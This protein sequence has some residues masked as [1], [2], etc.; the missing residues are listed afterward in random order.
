MDIAFRSTT[1]AYSA[2]PVCVRFHPATKPFAD[3]GIQTTLSCPGTFGC[4]IVR[5]LLVVYTRDSDLFER[6]AYSQYAS[7][8]CR[9]APRLIER[10]LREAFRSSM[11]L[12]RQDRS[13]IEGDA[14]PRIVS[15]KQYGEPDVLEFVDVQA[16]TPQADEVR[17]RVKA[18]GLNRAESMWRRGDYVEPVNL[19]ARLG[20]ESA[21][22]VDAIGSNV[23]HVAVGDAVST[24]PS[25]SMNDYG[26]YGEVVVAPKHAVV[27]IADGVSF[28]QATAIWNPFITPYGAFIESGAVKPG[29][30]VLITAASSSVGLGAIQM[31]NLAGAV[32]IALTRTSA[33][34]DE[35]RAQGAAHVIATEEQDLVAEVSRITNEQGARFAF[36]PVGG[37]AFAKLVDAMA[38]G[39]T[40]FVYGALSDDVTPLPMI[41]VLFKR[42]S[43]QGYNLFATTTDSERQKAATDFIFEAVRKGDLKPVI[44]KRFA[45]DDIV[46]A[47]R[48]LEKNQHIGRIVVEV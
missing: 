27:R 1:Q 3:R 25:F 4:R 44:S 21:G 24:V 11:T 15:F 37:P 47:H 12:S 33:K 26:M 29:D 35:L 10:M 9:R 6:G 18:I 34:A 38:P 17:I 42:L 36:D 2:I 48:E 32:T 16:P 45:F 46:E 19:P 30:F 28:E 8:Q 20:Y 43:I 39:G 5:I 23:T 40:L 7:M 31:A 13:P 41:P 22:I 14:M